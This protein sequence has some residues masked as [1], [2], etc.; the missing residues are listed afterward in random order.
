MTFEAWKPIAVCLAVAVAGPAFAQSAE[1]VAAHTDWSVFVAANPKECYIVSPPENW[2]ARRDGKTV[3]VNRGDI[4]LYV[5]FRPE[6]GVANEVSFNS[7][8]PLKPGNPVKL[9]IGSNSFN[10]S[11]GEGAGAEWAWTDP[12]DDARAVT[13]MR[14]GAEAK[15]TGV[16]ARGT[17]TV[18]TF[19]LSGLTAAITDAEARCK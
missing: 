5:S 16:S 4:R 6:R 2:V 10:L 3:E 8:Y 15:I 9:E 13:A 7:G 19:S 18:D 1:R 17:T 12:A 11:P 14:A